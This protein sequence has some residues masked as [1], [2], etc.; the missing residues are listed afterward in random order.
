MER[1]SEFT[2]RYV[3]AMGVDVPRRRRRWRTPCASRAQGGGGR[4]RGNEKV[5]A[6]LKRELRRPR[7]RPPEGDRGH[8]GAAEPDMVTPI[9]CAVRR[10]YGNLCASAAGAAGGDDRRVSAGVYSAC[11]R[12]THGGEKSLARSEGRVRTPPPM[13]SR[14]DVAW[15][16]WPAATPSTNVGFRFMRGSV[17]ASRFV[18]GLRI[19][20]GV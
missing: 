17:R 15:A 1:L 10:F 6:T 5:I 14:Q 16:V 9:T 19:R 18:A 7:R 20:V 8:H 13:R 11:Q 3:K 2:L 12:L 4:L